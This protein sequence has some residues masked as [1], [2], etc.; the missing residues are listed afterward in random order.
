MSTNIPYEIIRLDTS[1][2]QTPESSVLLIY[3]GGTFGMGQDENGRLIPFDFHELIGALAPRHVLIIAPY[4]D[5]NFRAESVERIAAAAN[6]VFKLY[7]KSEL[8]R[9]EHPDCGH[10]FPREMRDAAYALFD[11]V[12]R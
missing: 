2:P 7:G 1:A 9:V 12:L 4:K 11:S 6:Q 5:H 8:L 3:T 10:D